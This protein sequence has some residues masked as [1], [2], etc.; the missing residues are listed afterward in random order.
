MSYPPRTSSRTRFSGLL[1]ALVC[2]CALAGGACLGKSNAVY[3]RLDPSGRGTISPGADARIADG[4]AA[5]AV[6]TCTDHLKNAS[7]TDVDCG[8]DDCG[9]CVN[10]KSCSVG[11]DCLA[12]T[13]TAGVCQAAGCANQTKDGQ[14]TDVD[15]GGMQCSPCGQGR[16]CQLVRD[17]T[18]GTCTAGICEMPSC[19]DHMMNGSETDIDCGG[20]PCMACPPQAGCAVNQDCLT[21]VCTSGKCAVAT[22]LDGVRN[23]NEAAIDCGRNLPRLL[24]RPALRSSA[25]LQEWRVSRRSLRGGEL[26]RHGHERDR[27]G[28]RLWRPRAR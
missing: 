26:H 12:S 13:C 17:C 11:G 27:I 8:G 16:R 25:G 9:P 6:P 5:P 15:C 24:R 28:C 19:T 3:S 2:V 4:A 14:E 23:Q 1:I 7:E 10:G 18:S 21:G 22:C 20:T